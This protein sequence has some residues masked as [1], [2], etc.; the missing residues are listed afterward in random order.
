[1]AR[2]VDLR[3]GAG[4]VGYLLGLQL[5][6]C[7][8]R[9]FMQLRVYTLGPGHIGCNRVV[10]CR[11]EKCVDAPREGVGYHVAVAAYVAYVVCERRD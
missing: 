8:L 1:M 4:R 5:Q 10:Q 11:R 2:N 6:G 3:S 7:R 9:D